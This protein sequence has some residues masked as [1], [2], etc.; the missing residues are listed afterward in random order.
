MVFWEKRV[1]PIREEQEAWQE[2]FPGSVSVLFNNI[3]VP[4]IAAQFVFPQI[5]SSHSQT[6]CSEIEKW[7]NTTR[8]VTRRSQRPVD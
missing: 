8:D 7:N 5:S 2:L 3:Y 4:G 6:S 1:K